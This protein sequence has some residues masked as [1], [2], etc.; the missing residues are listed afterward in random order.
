[1]GNET[2]KR[3]PSR[4]KQRKRLRRNCS[5]GKD[6]VLAFTCSWVGYRRRCWP[7]LPPRERDAFFS[8]W[9]RQIFHLP[10]G[11]GA[12][13][14]G[15]H[16]CKDVILDSSISSQLIHTSSSYSHPRSILFHLHFILTST[17]L[18]S[19]FIFSNHLNH[20]KVIFTRMGYRCIQG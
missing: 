1:M 7:C 16:G 6:L 18:C 19:Y 17:V 5:L 12:P 20:A 9:A 11:T 3:T 2:R 4:V 13:R 15:T 14:N 8:I 10:T